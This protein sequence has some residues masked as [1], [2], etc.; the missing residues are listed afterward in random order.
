MTPAAGADALI[1][2][3]RK[4]AAGRGEKIAE[5][6]MLLARA[7]DKR[8]ADGLRELRSAL[9][10]LAGS[11]P[12]FGFPRSG[13]VARECEHLLDAALDQPSPRVPDRLPGIVSRL[14]Q[15]L[16]EEGRALDAAPAESPAGAASPRAASPPIRGLGAGV[17]VSAGDEHTEWFESELT[18]AGYTATLVRSDGDVLRVCTGADVV[19]INV[20]AGG[21]GYAICRRLAEL[22]SPPRTRILFATGDTSFDALKVSGSKADRMIHRASDLRTILRPVGAPSADRVVARIL[23]VEDDPECAQAIQAILG[24]AGHSVKVLARPDELFGQLS[25]FRPELLLLDYDL[26]NM[27]GFEIARV[28]RSD[29]RHEAT[30]IVFVTTRSEKRDRRAAT[31]AGGDDF[32]TKP[33]TADELLDIV[34]AHLQRHRAY[35][36]RL[37]SDLLT[38]LLNRGAAMTAVDDM[39]AAAGRRGTAVLVSILDLDHFKRVN[40]ELGHPTGDR[41]LREM[42]AHLRSTLLPGDVAGRLGG[43]EMVVALEGGTEEEL[44]ERLDELRKSLRIELRSS[45]GGKGRVTFSAGAAMFPRD[46]KLASELLRQA[47]HALYA[48]KTQGRNRVVS[49]SSLG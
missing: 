35:R 34:H 7:S 2:L 49:I 9:H 29:A 41:V 38:E 17:I 30:P 31:A 36:R 25:D 48:A 8:T 5:V 46:G 43:E 39:L 12:M 14:A 15:M 3:R 45:D 33:F 42:G 26:P 6:C 40:D 44:L 37:D 4:F 28:V 23:S 47:D 22:P 32:V 19:L 1:A 20:A 13:E 24:S 21:D 18:A 10:K 11:A 16:D 27:N